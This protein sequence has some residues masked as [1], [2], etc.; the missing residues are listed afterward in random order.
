MRFPPGVEGALEGK[1]PRFPAAPDAGRRWGADRG[2]S[3]GNKRVRR[4][5]SGGAAPA[6]RGSPVYRTLQVR[7]ML[8]R[9]RDLGERHVVYGRMS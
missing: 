2:R 1:L 4:P 9:P 7:E 3:S 8:P 5:Q 6:P